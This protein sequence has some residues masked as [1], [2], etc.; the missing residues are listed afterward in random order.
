[1]G[2]GGVSGTV[3][4]SICSNPALRN[5]PG[6]WMFRVTSSSSDPM[7][8]SLLLFLE[9]SGPF[10]LTGPSLQLE[11]EVLVRPPPFLFPLRLPRDRD[12]FPRDEGT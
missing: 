2:G 9:L 12:P 10:G 1:M 5:F 4:S 3:S 6:D 8:S 7:T 11:E